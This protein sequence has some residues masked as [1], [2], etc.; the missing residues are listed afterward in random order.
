MRVVK[1]RTRPFFSL[2]Q[3]KWDVPLFLLFLEAL[4]LFGSQFAPEELTHFRFGEHI[5]EFYILRDFVRG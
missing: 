1:I 2:F 5:A 4:S 3:N